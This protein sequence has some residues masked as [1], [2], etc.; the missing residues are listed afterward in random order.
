M[1]E[2]FPQEAIEGWMDLALRQARLSEA[3]DEVPVGAVLLLN[4]ELVTQAGNHMIASHDPSAHAEMTA[5][6]Q[7]GAILGNYRLP[8]TVLVV[9]LE[10]CLMCYSAMVHARIGG[11]VYAAADFKTGVFS[12]G[13]LERIG[14]IFNHSFPVRN[15]VRGEEASSLLSAFFLRRRERKG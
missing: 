7:G 1:F 9:T 14:H 13:A 11:L 6:R 10:P 3:A 2:Q 12:T 8:Q 5:L 4:G 15:G